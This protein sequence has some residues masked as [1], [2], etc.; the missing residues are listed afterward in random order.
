[1]KKEK[2][3]EHYNQEQRRDLQTIGVRRE[4]T[5]NIVRH[6]NLGEG[7]GFIAYSSLTHENANTVIRE[8]ITYFEN[9]KQNF[10]WKY[11][12]HDEPSDLL[13]RLRTHGF[14]IEEHEASLVLELDALPETLQQQ[15]THD[16]RLLTRVEELQDVQI[17]ETSVWGGDQSNIIKYLANNLQTQPDNLRVYV[18]YVDNKPV[19]SA[20]MFFHEGSQFASLWGGST[21]KDYRGLGIYTELVAIR[22]QKAIQRGAK[23]L[24]V[25]ASPMS[26]PILEKLGFQFLT[27]TYPCKWHITK[28]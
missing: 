12:T 9:L 26:Q 19:S 10:E 24:T 11:Y 3:L 20:W 6:V 21:I 14:T 25:D 16:I 5:E 13:E 2:I 18:A 8:Q 17:V 7:E 4:V 27:Y 15:S 22:A 23:F 28:S 1:L